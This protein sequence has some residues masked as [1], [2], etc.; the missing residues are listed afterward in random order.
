MI[1]S[2]LNE[3]YLSAAFFHPIR[4][5]QPAENAFKKSQEKKELKKRKP[6]RNTPKPGSKKMSDTFLPLIIFYTSSD[7]IIFL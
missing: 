1:F 2:T 4:V 7:N 3:L 6:R 5:K